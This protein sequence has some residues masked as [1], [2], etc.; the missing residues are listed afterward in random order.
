MGRESKSSLGQGTVDDLIAKYQAVYDIPYD[1]T[2]SAAFNT[3]LSDGK[4]VP[5]GTLIELTAEFGV[6][7][8]TSALTMFR[9]FCDNGEL[10][11]YLDFESGVNPNQIEAM[12]LTKHYRSAENPE[13]HFRH[14]NPVTFEDLDDIF[15]TYMNSD[16]PPAHVVIDSIS[17][18]VPGKLM[19][20]GITEIEPGLCARFQSN[21]FQKYKAGCKRAGI[22]VWLINQVRTKIRFMGPSTTEP[23]GGNALK[24]WCDIRL[25]L[26]LEE[27]LKKT[28]ELPG[29]KK[30]TVQYGSVCSLFSLKNRYT[31]P[32]IKVPVAIYFGR[33]ISN[34]YSYVNFLQQAGYISQGGAGMYTIKFPTK[35]GQAETEA[36]KVRGYPKLEQWVKEN[37]A[38]VKTL[39]ESLGGFRLKKKEEEVP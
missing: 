15:T 2:G 19:D 36:V 31:F 12:G 1:N 9:R 28:T 29:G 5:K 24:H 16:K 20:K 26:E 23:S 11:D 34:I 30:E 3:V 6:G 7:K 21:F 33:G 8:T 4:G 32:Y 35:E 27:R 14:M 39:I 38:E 25:M 18:I 17:A 10:C 13:G 22:T 37:A